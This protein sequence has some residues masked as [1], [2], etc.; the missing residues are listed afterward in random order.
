V[1]GSTALAHNAYGRVTYE[2]IDDEVRGPDWVNAMEFKPQPKPARPE[3]LIG[4]QV[5]DGMRVEKII[6]HLLGL[7]P[8]GYLA[9]PDNGAMRRKSGDCMKPKYHLRH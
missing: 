1:T 4:I 3:A 9:A 5:E 2:L 8:T 7:D 6:I